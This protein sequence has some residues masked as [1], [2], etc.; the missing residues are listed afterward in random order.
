M[1]GE[2]AIGAAVQAAGTM[3]EVAP[4]AAEATKGIATA[5]EVSQVVGGITA[6]QEAVLQTA[7]TAASPAEG[8]GV[9]AN[10]SEAPAA[11]APSQ[12]AGI[13]SSETTVP[14]QKPVEN[15]QPESVRQ[16]TSI[17]P[18]PENTEAKAAQA[19]QST[20]IPKRVAEDP[21]YK[22]TW[23]DLYSE[24]KVKSP[25][26]NVD[27]TTIAAIDRQATTSYYENLAEQ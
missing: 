3:T 2:A 12:A 9:I 18:V 17:Q 5:A 24:A 16:E 6:A 4:V 26:G 8:L 7:G 23:G 20:V 11:E 25:D 27:T 19:E 14:S 15:I 22:K 10:M 1:A 13:S 21:Q